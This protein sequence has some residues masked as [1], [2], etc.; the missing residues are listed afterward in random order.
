M[1]FGRRV[2]TTIWLEEK[3]EL[4]RAHFS[5]HNY[6]PSLLS[7]LLSCYDFSDVTSNVSCLN[8]YC[9]CQSEC[10]EAVV[11]RRA[12]AI[13]RLNC[14]DT[15]TTPFVHHYRCFH[16]ESK[17]K[18]NTT[19]DEQKIASHDENKNENHA[20]AVSFFLQ[21]FFSFFFPFTVRSSVVPLLFCTE[22]FCYYY[23]FFLYN[24]RCR[25]STQEFACSLSAAELHF[26][27][28]HPSWVCGASYVQ[29]A[30]S[31]DEYRFPRARYD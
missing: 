2:L 15:S 23:F 25:F 9:R 26:C 11:G 6:V 8:I 17:Q 12:M 29:T 14:P 31:A 4:S 13:E 19:T 1:S 21:F 7:E 16:N 24:L 3:L 18:T 20:I 10:R 22:R 5:F 28:S 30:E 27:S